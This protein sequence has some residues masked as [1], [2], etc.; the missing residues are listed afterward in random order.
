MIENLFENSTFTLS[1]APP[2]GGDA[3]DV[4]MV[5]ANAKLDKLDMKW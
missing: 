4:T 5:D 3:G 1:K 2:R